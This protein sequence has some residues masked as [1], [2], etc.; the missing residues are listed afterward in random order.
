MLN[1]VARRSKCDEPAVR[2][3]FVSLA[4]QVPGARAWGEALASACPVSVGR[5]F[6]PQIVGKTAAVMHAA[7]LMA[8]I[9]Y[10]AAKY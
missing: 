3:P 4:I 2:S 7:T 9:D 8:N 6:C 10:G 5:L 1:L